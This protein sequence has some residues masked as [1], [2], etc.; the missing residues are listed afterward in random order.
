MLRL[1]RDFSRKSGQEIQLVQG[2][3]R[4]LDLENTF[5]GI[6]CWS[7]SFG[8]FEP[9]VNL[10]VLMRIARAIKP[11]GRFALDIANRDF[12][13]P[14]SP[15][16]AWYQRPGVICMDEVH[17]NSL[18]SRL[19]VKRMAMFQE[20][21]SREL[22]YSIRLYSLHEITGLLEVAGFRVLEVSG[23]RAHRGAFFDSESPRIMATCQRV[24]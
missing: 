21:R 5:D 7:T 15:N 17:F 9:E 13:A 1:A 18:N 22:N 11:G 23:Q 12:H 6:Y 10:D 16:M 20:G 2:D 8:F 4:Q 19:E 14:R 24:T 3:M